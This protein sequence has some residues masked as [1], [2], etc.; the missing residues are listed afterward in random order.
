MRSLFISDLHLS[1]DRPQ[2]NERFFRFVEHDAAGADALYVLGDLFEY[3]IG[4][5][6]LETPFNAVVAA[7]LRRLADAGT[8]VQVMHGNRD[9]LLGERF[10]RASGATLLADPSVIDGTLL[11]HGD[12]LC[13]D[14]H[15]YQAW[16]ARRAP[17]NGN[18]ASSPSRS[19]SA[20]PRFKDCATRAGK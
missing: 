12:T 10:A 2:A 7:F 16:R 15:D 5:E 4:D 11:M 6:D 14:D 17:T 9:F 19:P 13:T 3:W 20:A 1:E 8:R 18:A